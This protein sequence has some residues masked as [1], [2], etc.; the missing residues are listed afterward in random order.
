MSTLTKKIIDK[1][2]IKKCKRDFCK[3]Y[4]SMIKHQDSLT[5]DE[6]VRYRKCFKYNFNQIIKTENLILSAS[7]D[8][9][10]PP[11]L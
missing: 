8:R 1:I 10:Y 9:D 2:V 11:L 7:K 6:T 5:L 3:C 4:N